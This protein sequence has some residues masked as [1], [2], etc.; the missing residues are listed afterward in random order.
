V[1]MWMPPP[2]ALRKSWVDSNYNFY[3]RESLL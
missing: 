1:P 2:G 3:I